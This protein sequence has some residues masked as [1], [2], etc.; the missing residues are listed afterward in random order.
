MQWTKQKGTVF[1]YFSTGELLFPK[2]IN[3]V[4]TTIGTYLE[5]SLRLEIPLDVQLHRLTEHQVILLL[6]K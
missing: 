6:Q 3:A 4:A 5:D 2:K 1:L